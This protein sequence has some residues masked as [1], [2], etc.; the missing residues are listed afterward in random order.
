MAECAGAFEGQD[1]EA[2]AAGDQAVLHLMNAALG[3]VDELEQFVHFGAG[4]DLGADA[5]DGL[6]GV[7]PG[8]G[9]QAEGLCAEPSMDGG[10]EAAAL[11]ADLVGA[12]DSGSRAG[13]T[14]CEK[15]STSWVTTL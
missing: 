12:E 7:E 13:V 15:G 2:A 3:G 6:G 5:F 11:Q 9:E 8:A 1:G 14:V 10:L 4:G